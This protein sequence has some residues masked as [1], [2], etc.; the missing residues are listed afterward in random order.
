VW[1]EGCVR[2]G[3]GVGWGERRHLGGG[4]EGIEPR[5]VVKN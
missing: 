2:G 5:M 4:F 3:V 1:E